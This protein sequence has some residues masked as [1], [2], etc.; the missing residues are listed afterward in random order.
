MMRNWYKNG[1]GKDIIFSGIEFLLYQSSS[2]GFR[3]VVQGPIELVG[4][5]SLVEIDEP[6]GTAKI[7]ST[8]VFPRD[9]ERG[10]LKGGLGLIGD[11]LYYDVINTGHPDIF[12]IYFVTKQNRKTLSWHSGDVLEEIEWRFRHHMNQNSQKEDYW[13]VIN[14]TLNS[15][16]EKMQDALSQLK[17]L[18]GLIPICASCKKIRDDT[19][20]WNQ[21]ESYLRDHSEAE[22]THSICPDCAKKLYPDL[23]NV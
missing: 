6:G 15:A 20:Y 10:V 12:E 23:E 7:T 11:M 21:L 4:D 2:N 5:F 16:Y 1:P 14:E 3:S 8:T 18:T 17:V 22:F 19:G 9:M 13:C